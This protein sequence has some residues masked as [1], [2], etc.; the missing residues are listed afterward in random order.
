MLSQ[1]CDQDTESEKKKGKEER[2]K[3]RHASESAT[4]DERKREAAKESHKVTA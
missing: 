4:A 2:T 3:A 1:K